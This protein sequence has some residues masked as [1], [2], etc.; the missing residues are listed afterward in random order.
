MGASL[1]AEHRAVGERRVVRHP[2][3]LRVVHP[4]APGRP[5]ADARRRPAGAAH[6]LDDLQRVQ[7]KV[8]VFLS[9]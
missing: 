9:G 2:D 8:P 4:Q 3:Q 5:Q 1:L 6:V 7:P